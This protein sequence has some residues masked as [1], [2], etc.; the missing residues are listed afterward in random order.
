MYKSVTSNQVFSLYNLYIF[1]TVIAFLLGIMISGGGYSAPA[2]MVLGAFVGLILVYPA[3]KIASS[4]PDEFLVQ[5]GSELVGR[6]LHVLFITMIIG[7]QLL[8]AAVNLRQLSDFLLS[9]YLIGTP[10]WAVATIFSICIAYAV[11]SGVE[12]IFRIAQGIYLISALAF[13]VIPILAMQEIQGD[14]LIALVT[15]L[16]LQDIGSGSYLMA[17]ML[18]ELAYLFLVFPYLKTPKKV[19]RTFF[20]TTLSSLVIILSHTIPVLLTFG[21]ELGANLTYPDMELIRFIRVGSF[22]ET[23]DPV[24][25]ILW[26]TSIFVKISFIIFTAS[27][28]IAQLTGVK[29]HKPLTLPVTAFSVIFSLTIAKSHTELTKFLVE[30]TAPV[31]IVTE[32]LIPW[33]YWIAGAVRGSGRNEKPADGKSADS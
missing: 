14:M 1:T 25:I 13:I 16:S 33:V 29:D 12:T 27:L 3:Y 19:Y 22:I 11:R 4:R 8:L 30:G 17:V 32:F 6:W 24:L 28:C 21:P 31:L 15:H 7:A 20:F 23:L 18:G 2:A 26:L 9:V 5:Y 10:P